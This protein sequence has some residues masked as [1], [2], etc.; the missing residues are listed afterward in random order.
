MHSERREKHRWTAIAISGV[1]STVISYHKSIILSSKAGCYFFCGGAFCTFLPS[2]TVC[3]QVLFY[4]AFGVDPSAADCHNV[5][6]VAK[7]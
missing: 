1:G 7:P 6:F 4:A 5:E 2:F 3:S